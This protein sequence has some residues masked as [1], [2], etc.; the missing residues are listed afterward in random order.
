MSYNSDT[1]WQLYNIG[2]ADLALRYAE[3]ASEGTTTPRH[4]PNLNVLSIQFYEGVEAY[5][6]PSRPGFRFRFAKSTTR[7]VMCWVK[8]THSWQYST[9]KYKLQIRYYRPDG[10]MVGELEDEIEVD[11]QRPSFSYSRGLGWKEPGN[12]Q[13][14]DYRVEIL[15]DRVERQSGTFTI[16][17]DRP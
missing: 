17:D 1:L 12:W 16:F 8:F 5:S 14:G 6:G 11:P 10:S 15:I 9:F 7:F 3:I 13:P 2:G 4:E